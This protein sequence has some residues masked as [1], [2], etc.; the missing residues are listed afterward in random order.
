LRIAI[1]GRELNLPI[2]WWYANGLALAGLAFLVYLALEVERSGAWRDPAVQLQLVGAVGIALLAEPVFEPLR[3]N[4]RL[5][6]VAAAVHTAILL[7]LPP[8]A[9]AWSVALAGGLTGIFLGWPGVDQAWYRLT[10]QGLLV[11]VAAQT[12]VVLGGSAP[13][14]LEDLPWAVV[15]AS[16]YWGVSSLL[17]IVD[18]V[19]GH[20]ASE[21]Y[22][23]A[24]LAAFWRQAQMAG[25]GLGLAGFYSLDLP[26]LFYLLPFAFLAQPLA[27]RSRQ[28]EALLEILH[29]SGR[30]GTPADSARA[31]GEA[32]VRF[33]G[34]DYFAFIV[35]RRGRTPSWTRMVAV[36]QAQLSANAEATLAERAAVEG[37]ELI[38]PRLSAGATYVGLPE[39]GGLVVLP[40][41]T[42][43]GGAAAVLYFGEPLIT[44][45]EQ[46][47]AYLRLGVGQ[48]VARRPAPAGPGPGAS[49]EEE[50]RR[51]KSQFVANLSHE[52]RTPL[53]TLAGYAEMLATAQFPPQRV[54]EM[55]Q[56]MYDDASRLGSMIDH[57]LDMSR[58]EAGDL[59]MDREPVQI[60][61]VI[62]T[63]VE[64]YIAQG[65]RNVVLQIRRPLPEV[66]ADREQIGQVMSNLIDNALRYS[67]EGSR[68]DVVVETMGGEL[69][70]GVRDKGIGIA[71]DEQERVFESFYR[72]ERPRTN[73]VRGAGLGL[74]LSKH[75]VEAH[76][77]RIW[78]ESEPGRGS[79]F[80]FTLPVAVA[81]R[82]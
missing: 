46:M 10:R 55:S 9:A 68:V 31:V 61:K 73:G 58:L 38:W 26:P 40:V 2:A 19:T 11:G 5:S 8:W 27:I 41:K 76:G 7:L 20:Q 67:P 48:I 50:M 36:G 80:Y 42:D 52:L 49:L 70:V 18:L 51:F 74:A 30:P 56:A 54:K 32:I 57:L 72:A 23:S 64:A 71:P 75:I 22:G 66:Y 25:V 13:L 60:D 82:S 44:R 15:A 1:G 62:E 21:S 39:R 45:A 77:G 65:K 14:T 24:T 28:N 6:A 35:E 29:A 34:A 53:T 47:A 16:I 43:E 59:A 12:Y 37:H 33:A 4:R 17:A 81:E 63:T 69:R 78:V 79:A 3:A